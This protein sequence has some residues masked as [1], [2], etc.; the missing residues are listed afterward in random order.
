M[1]RIELTND[2]CAGRPVHARSRWDDTGSVKA[3][4]RP[5]AGASISPADAEASAGLHKSHCVA[6]GRRPNSLGLKQEIQSH[7]PATLRS[8]FAR[9]LRLFLIA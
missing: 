7:F 4:N 3:R 8:R 6:I 5:L 1:C 2:R 9:E